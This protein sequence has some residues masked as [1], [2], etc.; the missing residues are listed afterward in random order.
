MISI[1]G[2]VKKLINWGVAEKPG[3]ARPEAEPKGGVR[4]GGGP[5]APRDFFSKPDRDLF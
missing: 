2:L 1:I 5:P 3:A 4:G